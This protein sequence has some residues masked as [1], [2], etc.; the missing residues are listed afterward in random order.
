MSTFYSSDELRHLL[1]QW[2]GRKIVFELINRCGVFASPFA[3]ERTLLEYN[4]GAHAVG[5]ELFNDCMSVSPKLT[6]MMLEEQGNY[7]NDKRADEQRRLDTRTDLGD[8]D[9]DFLPF[10]RNNGLGLG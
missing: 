5:V 7:D 6:A 1:S 2:Q 10:D 4:C 8:D 9:G 3:Q